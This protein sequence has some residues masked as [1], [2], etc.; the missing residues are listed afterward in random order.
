MNS[1]RSGQ[2]T[3]EAVCGIAALMLAG[4]L[5]FQLLATG[6]TATIADGAA[7]A[8]A[9]ALIRGEPVEPAVLEALPGWARDRVSVSRVGSR[10]KVR[11]RPPSLFSSMSEKLAVSAEAGG[12][13]G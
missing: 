7:E 13:P 5:C 10:V 4:L 2:A 8:G 3:V 6:Y 11:L 1:G 9:V 12:R